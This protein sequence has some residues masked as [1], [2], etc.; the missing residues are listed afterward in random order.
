MPDTNTPNP[1]TLDD[2]Y[3]MFLTG[4]YTIKQLADHCR[5]KWCAQTI[6]VKISERLKTK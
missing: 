1:V 2:L 4:N 3:D 6:S 5:G